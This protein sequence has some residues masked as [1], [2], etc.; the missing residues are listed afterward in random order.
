MQLS[1]TA[2]RAVAGA[3]L[4]LPIVVAVPGVAFAGDDDNYGGPGGHGHHHGGNG[5]DCGDQTAVQGGSLVDVVAGVNPAANVGNIL[6]LFG[7]QAQNAQAGSNT[8]GGIQQAG[9]GTGGQHAFQAGDLVGAVLGVDPAANVGNIGNVGGTQLQNAQ[10]GSNTNGGIQQAGGDERGRHESGR[11]HRGGGDQVAA[12][13]PSLIGITAGVAP[14]L[15]VGNIGNIGGTQVQ[16]AQTASNT[17]SGVQQS[18]GDER[19]RHESGRHHRGGDA[20]QVAAQGPSLIGVTAGV[21]P[22][23]NVGNILNLFGT[24]AQNAQT[25][26]E[27]NSGVQQAH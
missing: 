16:N 6:N 5:G 14:A 26:S 7:A 13:G 8:N 19:G 24:Q 11:H 20:D 3:A 15:N 1:T 18:G 23:L 12:Q 9:C 17:N 10:A 4:A 22:A 21:A 25:A 27:T 2:R